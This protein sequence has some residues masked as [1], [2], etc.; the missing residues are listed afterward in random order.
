MPAIPMV[1]SGLPHDFPEIGTHR[2]RAVDVGEIPGLD[3]AVCP[4]D[5]GKDAD[6]VG[7]LLLEIRADPRPAR[8]TAHRGDIG[9]LTGLLGERNGVGKLPSIAAAEEARDLDGARLSPQF[10]A[11]LDFA[12]HLELAEGGIQS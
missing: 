5:A 3:V 1:S 8:V 2:Y 12:N 4:A 7:H 11:P 6:A 10:V 9:G